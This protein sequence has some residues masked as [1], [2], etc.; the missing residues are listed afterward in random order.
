VFASEE[1]NVTRYVEMN[2]CIFK[3]GFTAYMKV[4]LYH[5]RALHVLAIEMQFIFHKVFFPVKVVVK[6]RKVPWFWPETEVLG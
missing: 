3:A 4:A 2:E 5:H 1:F 6:D